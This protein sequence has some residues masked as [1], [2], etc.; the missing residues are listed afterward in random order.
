[1]EEQ[2]NDR[3]HY[4]ME[5]NLMIINAI[6]GK[7][8]NVDT[9]THAIFRFQGRQ[10]RVSSTNGIASLAGKWTRSLNYAG[11]RPVMGECWVGKTKHELI[12]KAS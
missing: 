4:G 2:S 1:M 5:G 7:D 9:S 10:I 3:I 8:I 6:R 11:G 12:I